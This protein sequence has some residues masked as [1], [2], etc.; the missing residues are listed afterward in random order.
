MPVARKA[1]EANTQAAKEADDTN[2]LLRK[3]L[4]QQEQILK[5]LASLKK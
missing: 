3:I 2:A 1:L 4:E 5:A